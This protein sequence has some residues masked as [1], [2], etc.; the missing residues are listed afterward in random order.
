MRPSEKQATHSLTHSGRE[1]FRAILYLLSPWEVDL[2]EGMA[3]NI[4]VLDM[5]KLR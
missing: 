4:S 5:K 2:K 1:P 3:I